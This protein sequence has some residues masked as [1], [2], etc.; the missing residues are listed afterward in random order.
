MERKANMK[1]CGV[2]VYGGGLNARAWIDE[3]KEAA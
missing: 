2:I 3:A 1:Q